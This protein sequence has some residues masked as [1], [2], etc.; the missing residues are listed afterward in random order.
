MHQEYFAAIGS[1]AQGRD[2]RRSFSAVAFSVS[3]ILFS[4]SG[5]KGWSI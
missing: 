3:I 1:A 5:Q 2:L 4:R